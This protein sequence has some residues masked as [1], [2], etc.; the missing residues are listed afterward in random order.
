MGLLLKGRGRNERGR[1]G[2]GGE[3]D[4]GEGR[5]GKEGGVER[6]MRGA[7]SAPHPKL[8]PQNYFPGAGAESGSERPWPFLKFTKF[9]HFRRSLGSAEHL[10]QG[11]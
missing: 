4:G 9:T 1:E 6:G 2:R 10:S 11:D 5:E 3:G 7:G 8:G